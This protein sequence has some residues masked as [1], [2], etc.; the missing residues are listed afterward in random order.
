MEKYNPAPTIDFMD[1]GAFETVFETFCEMMES[2][3]TKALLRAA[4]AER[5]MLEDDLEKKRTPRER[6][7]ISVLHFC[8]SLANA[9]RGLPSVLPVWRIE[10]WAHYREIV[11][12]LADTGELPCCTMEQFDFTFCEAVALSSRYRSAE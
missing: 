9:T 8:R 5:R 6:D 10:H 12:R 4:E 11:R 2:I 1:S 7:A 3:P